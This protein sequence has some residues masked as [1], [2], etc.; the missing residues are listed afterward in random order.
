ML[1]A[2]G[3]HERAAGPRG[4]VSPWRPRR[5]GQ[6]LRLAHAANLAE[7][8]TSL[9]R[10]DEAMEVIEHALSLVPPAGSRLQ[11]LRLA[12]SIALARG[13]FDAAAAASARPA[14]K[15]PPAAAR[16]GPSRR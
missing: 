9:G 3:E 8:L 2:H 12:G 5:A 13:D 6:D 15:R 14:R 11:L 10:W 7:A 16:S 1:E 4:A